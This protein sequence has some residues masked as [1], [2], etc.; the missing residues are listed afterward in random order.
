MSTDLLLPCSPFPLHAFP[1]PMRDFLQAASDAFDIDPAAIALPM[2]TVAGAAIGNSRR[3]Q[4]TG[5]HSIPPNIWSAILSHDD[6]RLS[7]IH[8]LILAPLIERHENIAD[9]VHR[10]QSQYAL[11]LNDWNRFHHETKEPKPLPPRPDFRQ[12]FFTDPDY[13]RLP[14]YLARQPRGCLIVQDDLSHWF[15]S[16]PTQCLSLFDAPPFTFDRAKSLHIRFAPHAFLAVTG[17][18]PPLSRTVSVRDYST[19]P[20]IPIQF[21]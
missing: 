14:E 10:S 17:S 19:A 18:L 12:Y 2:L 11:D 3:L 9:F 16:T 13:R 21:A 4:L 8:Q 1:D 20:P 6:P 5:G 15:Q 7:H